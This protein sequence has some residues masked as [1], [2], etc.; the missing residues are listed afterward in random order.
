MIYII[1]A[2]TVE[3]HIK[4]IVD[5]TN[6][7]GLMHGVVYY[8]LA[9]NLA[10]HRGKGIEVPYTDRRE[11]F[12][13]LSEMLSVPVDKLE[14]VLNHLVDNDGVKKLEEGKD[15]YDYF[16]DEEKIGIVNFYNAMQE[17]LKELEENKDAVHA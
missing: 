14:T 4:N 2:R 10:K 16:T 15:D 1:K 9:N 13:K 3:E 11:D 8:Q 17:V 12:D 5:I 7:Y 6:K